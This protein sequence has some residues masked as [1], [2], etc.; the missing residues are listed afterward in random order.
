MLVVVRSA[1]Q[2]VKKV[3]ERYEG[4]LTAYCAYLDAV[5]LAKF[6]RVLL[7]VVETM[8]MRSETADSLQ[9]RRGAR[10]RAR[11]GLEIIGQFTP[12]LRDDE[13]AQR[14]KIFAAHYARLFRGRGVTY[15]GKSGIMSRW[16]RF[17]RA[18]RGT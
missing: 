3:A 11:R 15:I 7:D 16:R 2:A 14:I 1:H 5:E 4:A 12:R 6:L 8:L 9:S 18:W 17:W 10:E 13:L